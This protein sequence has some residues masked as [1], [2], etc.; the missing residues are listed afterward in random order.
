MDDC[1]FIISNSSRIRNDFLLRDLDA[2]N[3]HVLSLLRVL[4]AGQNVFKNELGIFLF[5]SVVVT[6]V[7]LSIINSFY[8]YQIQFSP[9]ED[10][11]VSYCPYCL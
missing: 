11:L 10:I 2:G 4:P 3:H 5:S 9:R 7:H 6:N 1:V 8:L